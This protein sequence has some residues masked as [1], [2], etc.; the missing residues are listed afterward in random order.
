MSP[1]VPV[2]PCKVFFVIFELTLCDSK[3]TGGMSMGLLFHQCGEVE[4]EL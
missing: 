4:G 3:G 2:S 1:S